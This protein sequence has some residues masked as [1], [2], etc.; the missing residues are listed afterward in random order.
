MF[1]RPLTKIL[2]IFHTWLLNTAM[3]DHIRHYKQSL[4]LKE[5]KKLTAE[6]QCGS[7]SINVPV[8][9]QYLLAGVPGKY[10]RLQGLYL[11][12]VLNTEFGPGEYSADGSNVPG[13]YDESDDQ[14]IHADNPP[15]IANGV[16]LSSYP[17]SWR[18]GRQK[19]TDLPHRYNQ[20]TL[21]KLKEALDF[22]YFDN[23]AKFF[24]LKILDLNSGTSK[25]ASA[26]AG[27]QS[28]LTWMKKRDSSSTAKK[29]RRSPVKFTSEGKK[30]LEEGNEDY[31]GEAEE[32]NRAATVLL[33]AKIHNVPPKW[34]TALYFSQREQL[35]V[36]P[37]AEVELPRS[38]FT[39]ELWVKPEGGQNNPVFIAGWYCVLLTKVFYMW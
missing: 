16:Q 37:G 8:A 17:E 9:Q 6:E 31:S 11:K 21:S 23:Y 18:S 12:S 39:L 32:K 5:P 20:R 1:I 34:M 15:I 33:H 26:T 30:Q 35:K 25:S 36:N 24:S 4:V 2:V 10:T 27:L 7:V 19:K 3:S 13:M 14:I 28:P 22:S 29:V 38:S